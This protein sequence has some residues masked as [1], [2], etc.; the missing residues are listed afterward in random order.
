MSNVIQKG[1]A[2][3]PTRCHSIGLSPIRHNQAS[4]SFLISRILEFSRILENSKFLGIPGLGREFRIFEDSGIPGIRST[5]V[6]SCQL[7]GG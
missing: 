6:P 5:D 7:T 4:I 1:G 3:N 2:R